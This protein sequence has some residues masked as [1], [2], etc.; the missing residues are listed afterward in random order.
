MEPTSTKPLISRTRPTDLTWKE[1]HSTYHEIDDKVFERLERN[2]AK[3]IESSRGRIEMKRSEQIRKIADKNRASKSIWDNDTAD[4]WDAIAND[5]ALL[6][7][8]AEAAEKD[9]PLLRRFLGFGPST[10]T[11]LALAAA[12]DAGL[13]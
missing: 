6:E 3:M 8:V 2:V 9:M 7:A 10:Q 13:L 4:G 5:F 1:R 11:E 12:R